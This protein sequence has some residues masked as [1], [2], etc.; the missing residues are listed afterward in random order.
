[1]GH[2]SP[3]VTKNDKLDK[4][5]NDYLQTQDEMDLEGIM[6]DG[7]KAMF[8]M[9]APLAHFN[10]PKKISETKYELKDYIEVLEDT[11][12]KIKE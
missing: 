2:V 3:R 6:N 11:L 7:N 9:T 4:N 10:N 8:M 12:A 5:F 1:M